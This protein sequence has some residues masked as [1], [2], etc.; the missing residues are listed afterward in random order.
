[1]TEEI[2]MRKCRACGKDT[3][4]GKPCSNDAC[5]WDEEAEQ[6]EVRRKRMHDQIAAELDE[7]DKKKTKKEQPKRRGLFGR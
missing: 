3:D 6:A 2:K 1:M 7:A 5:G 4:V